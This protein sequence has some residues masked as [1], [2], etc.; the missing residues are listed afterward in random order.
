MKTDRRGFL[1]AAAAFGAVGATRAWAQGLRI[2]PIREGGVDEQL[3]ITPIEITAGAS[4]PFKALHFS[5]THLNFWDVQ[6]FFG[7]PKKEEHF[8]QRWVRFPQALNS[9]YA[10]IDYAAS[11][12]LMMLHTGDLMDWNTRANRNVVERNLKGRDFFYA[13]GNHE[14]HS[15]QGKQPEMTHAEA[16]DA[17]RKAVGND[18]TVA[19]KVVNG[20]NIVAFDNGEMRLREETV[21]RV[22]AEFAKGLPVVL[23]CHIPPTY[24]PKFLENGLAMK[25][26]ILRGQGVPEEQLAKM[27]KSGP[28]E[29]HYDERTR[30]FYGWLREQK[31]LKAILC[32][33]THVE[34]Q[35]WFSETAQMYV[36]GGNYEG[37]G[38]EVTFC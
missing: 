5:D 27:R 15:S 13:I 23:M 24:T 12:N 37:C 25:R 35:D 7:N 34:E 28:I 9:L 22:K 3:K 4:A 16:R 14:Y 33:H 36:A 18:L 31:A 11:R 2:S 29:P 21:A 32:G 26:Q 1:L 6:D 10:T 17:M 38:Y 19:S 20:V 8:G 30:E